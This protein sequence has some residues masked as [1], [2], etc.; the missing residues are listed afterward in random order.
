[1][2]YYDTQLLPRFGWPNLQR[3]FHVYSTTLMKLDDY[4]R[5]FDMSLSLE[6]IRE[7]HSFRFYTPSGV[8]AVY[9]SIYYFIG[10]HLWKAVCHVYDTK[11][12]VHAR[13][14]FGKA[15]I[16]FRLGGWP[17]GLFFFSANA[18]SWAHSPAVYIWFGRGSYIHGSSKWIG[19]VGWGYGSSVAISLCRQRIF[20][21]HLRS[22]IT[23][24]DQL[25]SS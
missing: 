20:F 17:M 5:T 7:L 11:F 6:L 22:G 16:L 3:P 2:S 14:H 13:A 9:L 10:T 1:M 8:A 4:A 15:C 23:V 19:G 12:S 18:I 24:C 25:R 21:V